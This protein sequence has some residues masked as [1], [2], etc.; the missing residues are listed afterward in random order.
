MIPAIIAG[1]AVVLL[2]LI[3]LIVYLDFRGKKKKQVAE[4]ETKPAEKPRPPKP[5]KP[6]KPAPQ[7]KAEKV[8]PKKSGP[9]RPVVV[10][11]V[12]EEDTNDDE[13]D[14]EVTKVMSVSEN[15]EERY[16]IIKYSKSFLAKLIQSDDQTKLYY[17]EIK[18]RLLSYKGVKSR[19]SWKWETFRLGRQVVA[20]L[21][22]RGKTLSVCLPL[23]ADDYADTKYLVESFAD[24][25]SL[26]ETP[27]VYRI[28]ND[29]RMRYSFDLI[30]EVMNR[31]GIPEKEVEKIDYAAQYPYEKT[32]AL[33]ERKLIKELTDEEA[34]SGTRFRPSDI[35]ESVTAQEVD[36]IMTD[37]LAESL[38]EKSEGVSDKTKKDIINIDT[39]S[40][41][42]ESGEVVTLDA[43]KAR[44]K[45]FNR[46]TTYVKVLARGTLDKPLTVEADAFSI[47]AVKMII[48]T[49][50]KVIK[51]N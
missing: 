24:I 12:K 30:A 8:E 42:F 49:G 51:K 39:L 11:S 10:S 33:I 48:L 44:V 18:N 7:P 3:A 34:Q 50:G 13:N 9:V 20:K 36:N 17:S 26:A 6:V 19:M 29:R 35:R 45:G 14:D 46:K 1:S 2:A 40:Q 38:V 41:C 47:E 23:N 16:I 5:P 32:E 31:L 43:I 22:L 21:R 28:K 27:C 15:G 4:P 25:K 37:E